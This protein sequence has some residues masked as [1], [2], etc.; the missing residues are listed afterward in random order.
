MIR[1]RLLGPVDVEVD[2]APA[3]PELL[4]RK[5]LALLVYLARSPRGTRTRD[6]LTG[7]LWPD[8]EEAAARH[9]LNEAL[10]IL[11]RAGGDEAIDTS[12]GKIRLMEGVVRL[13][14]DDLE[15]HAKASDWASASAL[16]AGEFL[17]GF[18]LAGSEGFEDWLG[19]ERRSWRDRSVSAL[20]AH[21]EGLLRQGN[22]T[23]S[24][25]F[26]ERAAQLD[27]YSDAAARTVMGAL[28]VQGEAARAVAGYEAFAA[29][30]KSDL[31]TEPSRETRSLAARIGTVRAPRIPTA[32][33]ELDL[34]RTPLIGRQRQ[35]GSLLEYRDRHRSGATVLVIEGDAGTGKSR[36]LTELR[37]RL[38]VDGTATAL[39]RA[40]PS[41]QREAESGLLAL[42]R[43]GLL[44]VP[45]VASAPPS[46]LAA[47]AGRI[48]EWGDR[49]R[50]TAEPEGSITAAVSAVVEAAADAGPVALL[51][52]DAH[53]LDQASFEGLTALVRSL[54]GK[55][56]TVAFATLPHPAR[57][58][59]DQLRQRFG[60]DLHGA[61]VT[62]GPLDGAS[63]RDLTAWAFPRFDGVAVERLARR[64]A[65]DSAGLPLLAVELLS[66]VA[67][68]LELRESGSAW[69]APLR[70][71][72]ETLPG[73]LPDTIVA[74]LRI[75]FRRLTPEAQQVLSAVAVLGGRSTEPVLRRVTDL[76]AAP[77]SSALDELEWHRWLEADGTGYGFI[78]KIA[79]SVIERDMV[80][81]GQRARIIERA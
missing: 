45:G 80:T 70:T 65:A 69:P 57:E 18:S 43:G 76:P 15:A 27:P 5:H 48:P 16:I 35:L 53:W 20:L 68:G 23:A 1:C 78:A 54:A 66:A 67:S 74:A 73:D 58:E 3:P 41:D 71:L 6:H 12:A 62:L 31:G 11:R 55:P 4:W 34:R 52:D 2:G 61:A 14:T 21:A 39:A 40:V 81:K 46:A 64:I 30:L 44:D 38:L 63:L 75:G 51:I 77:L 7:L 59:L 79:V 56:L 25:R 29:R 33:P 60:R 36:L 32:A 26:A 28:A 72:T 24:F 19:V 8:K 22:A 9:S 37:A 42:A 13:D 17:E 47:V 50:S 49:F 10:R